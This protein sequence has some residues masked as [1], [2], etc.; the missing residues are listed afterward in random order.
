MTVS[1]T[2]RSAAFVAAD[3]EVLTFLLNESALL[4]ERRYEE[5]IDLLDDE[6]DYLVPMPLSR[7]DPALPAYDERAW[8]GSETK[9]SFKLKLLRISSD[10]AWADRPAAFQ[11]HHVS[12]VV[13]QPAGNGELIV[14]SNVLITRSRAP[15]PFS[16]FSAGRVDRLRP[17]A[18]R[19]FR[20]LAR[21][22]YLD[23]ELATGIQLAVVY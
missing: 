8:I 16:V 20:L 10:H 21:N 18:G 7:E 13:Q 15:A 12:N 3:Q 2:T 11:R 9:E 5:W 4:D 19:G 17:D 23:A 1:D 14:R 6:F 22:V